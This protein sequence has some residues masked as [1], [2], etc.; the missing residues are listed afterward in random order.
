MQYVL[1]RTSIYDNRQSFVE[2][3]CRISG[4]NEEPSYVAEPELRRNEII[5]D[6]DRQIKLIDDTREMV[7][8]EIRDAIKLMDKVHL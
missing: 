8:D 7:A 1:E 4:L 5:D 2:V 3:D 6:D